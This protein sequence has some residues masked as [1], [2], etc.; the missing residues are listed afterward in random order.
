MLLLSGK[1]H[2]ICLGNVTRGVEPFLPLRATA[3]G[4]P[5]HGSLSFP[6][7]GR[8]CSIQRAAAWSGRWGV[9]EYL[10]LCPRGQQAG[11]GTG[12]GPSSP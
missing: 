2:Q 10:S 4:L 12:E 9:L 6:A 11:L 8:N 1:S 3:P 5:R 7:L